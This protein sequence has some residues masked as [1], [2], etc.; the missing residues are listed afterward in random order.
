MRA[1]S[2]QIIE[3]VHC[4]MAI[5]EPGRIG[6]DIINPHTCFSGDSQNR[7][8]FLRGKQRFTAPDVNRPTTQFNDAFEYLLGP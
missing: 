5:D 3:H 7:L 2:L 4:P 1:G 8:Q 6:L